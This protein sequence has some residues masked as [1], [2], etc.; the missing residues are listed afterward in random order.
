VGSRL[1]LNQSLQQT[2]P[3]GLS[4]E[5]EEGPATS[6]GIL[7]PPKTGRRASGT[8]ASS[9][10]RR[11]GT[12]QPHKRMADGDPQRSR[13][14]QYQ[15][16]SERSPRT[17]PRQLKSPLPLGGPIHVLLDRF[18]GPLGPVE[19]LPPGPETPE[20][21]VDVRE[22]AVVG[23]AH[24]RTGTERDAVTTLM[25]TDRQ[26]ACAEIAIPGRGA[27][28]VEEGI[29]PY[30]KAVDQHLPPV[31][32]V[33]LRRLGLLERLELERAERAAHLRHARP[34]DARG[35]GAAELL[36]HRRQAVRLRNAVGLGQEEVLTGGVRRAQ[37]EQLVFVVPW[38]GQPPIVGA[39]QG[40]DRAFDLGVL[41]G[42]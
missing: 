22:V 18:G 25:E 10:E 6:L 31:L 36:D 1:H 34:P 38:S 35:A 39:Q 17:G 16:S 19:D 26:H 3:A 29:S 41:T 32:G 13:V 28:C 20:E 9:N 8:D 27:A 12:D 40:P 11:S 24:P 14:P 5:V 7:R 33:L 23:V 4:P 37:L 42:R 2:A 30:R 21:R 15:R